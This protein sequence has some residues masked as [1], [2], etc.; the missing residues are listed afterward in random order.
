MTNRAERRAQS[1]KSRAETETPDALSRTNPSLFVRVS[2]VVGTNP[3]AAAMGKARLV[4]LA[5][6][7][8]LRLYALEDGQ[9]VQDEVMLAAE[10]LATAARLREVQSV[11]AGVVGG[12]LSA[13][14]QCSQRGFVW[15]S[16]DAVA[17]EFGLMHA[18]DALTAASPRE[19]RDA[20]LH[21][22]QGGARST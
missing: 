3:V 11:P 9:N 20:W 16:R 10:V 7:F 21:I 8:R 17:V 4:R 14:V 2:R 22:R 13:L 19:V 15:R 5:R 18:V 12:A 6:D 1:R